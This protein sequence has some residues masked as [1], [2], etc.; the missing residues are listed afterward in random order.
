MKINCDVCGDLLNEKINS[1][2]N[3]LEWLHDTSK[4]FFYVDKSLRIVHRKCKYSDSDNYLLSDGYLFWY[5]G[6]KGLNL[7]LENI[8]SKA[9]SQEDGFEIIR[10]LHIYENE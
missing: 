10:R 2:D 7:L 4:P 9:Y 6:K 5:L 3:W 8:E 1:E